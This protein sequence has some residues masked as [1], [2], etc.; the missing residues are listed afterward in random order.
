M[1]VRAGPCAGQFEQLPRAGD[2]DAAD[3]PVEVRLPGIGVRRAVI[4]PSLRLQTVVAR[5]Q[6][7]EKRDAV[8]LQPA[9]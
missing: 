2:G 9:T 4:E 8:R 3:Q 7:L 5:G 6:V 1:S